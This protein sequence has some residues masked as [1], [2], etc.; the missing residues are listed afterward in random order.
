[1][2]VIGQ[3]MKLT[4]RAG[5]VLVAAGALLLI[6]A[7]VMAGTAPGA[8]AQSTTTFQVMITNQSH[9]PSMMSPGAYL[10]HLQAGALW[11]SGQLASPEIERIA[12]GG[13]PTEALTMPGSG[14][15]GDTPVV[16]DTTSFRVTAAPGMMLSLA[17]MLIASND[18]F[19]GVDSLALFDGTTPRSLMI[20]LTALD[21]GTEAN[22]ALGSGFAGG[23]P[24]PSEGAY[25][26]NNG[27][28]TNEAISAHTQYVGVQ[29]TLSVTPLP[30]PASTGNAGLA[31]QPGASS[32]L[33][34]GL[35]VMTLV[36]TAAGRL[37]AQHVAS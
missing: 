10:L 22:S 7:T 15:I 23:Q 11:Q 19:V 18:A 26:L 24:D 30:N 32:A 3:I 25:N 6:A 9:P 8:S 31:S 29:A 36:L 1:V 12:E 35:I 4:G 28:A 21:A 37:L 14:M 2:E 16:G 34:A 20:E 33:V 27:T 17:Q 13:D 5:H